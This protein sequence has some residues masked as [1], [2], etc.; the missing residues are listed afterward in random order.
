MKG[1]A[2]SGSDH[3]LGLALALA[4]VVGIAPWRAD[5]K[6]I[7]VDPELTC[8][9]QLVR[10]L[11]GYLDNYA[12]EPFLSSLLEG[13]LR[14]GSCIVLLGSSELT[15]TDHPA[16]PVNFFNKE[17]K[18]PLLA[19]GH[20]G[21]QS[22]SM[23]AQL[24]AANV[25]L[26]HARLVILVSP[27]WFVDKSA[28]EGTALAAFLE[29]QPSPSLYR[30]QQR[31]DQGDTLVGPVTRYLAEHRDELG[32]AQPIIRLMTRD[33]S[34]VDRARFCFSRPW[35]RFLVDE[36][37]AQMLRVPVLG[38]TAQPWA[39]PMIAPERWKELY[40]AGV[41]EHL[42]QCT[43]NK[44]FVTDTYYSEYVHGGTRQLDTVPVILN[45]EF[46][47]FAGLLNYVKASKGEPLF[48]LQ[49]LNPYVYTN[50]AAVDPTIN[51]IRR[52]LKAHDFDYLD[53]WVSDTTDFQPGTLTDVMHLGPLGWYRVDSAITAH[54]Q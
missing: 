9:T 45:N 4:V 51:A 8:S 25:S 5:R 38:G 43:N 12:R 39:M 27:S 19:L 6:L 26:E 15:S 23:H 36:T 17:L 52:E 33:A 53:L 30:I 31:I 10:P 32:A 44:V 46:R 21:N 14:D 40:Q 3:L 50:L 42:A 16:K 11:Q 2:A 54:F 41:Q 1:S 34:V 48:I 18:V 37:K 13:T 20:A 22:L 7:V 49:P 24:V 29:Y 47:D 35:T 28:T